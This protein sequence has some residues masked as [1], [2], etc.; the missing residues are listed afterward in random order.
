MA[1]SKLPYVAK[2]Q[3]GRIFARNAL[4]LTVTPKL[5]DRRY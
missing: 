1:G 5:V 4:L 3:P 2:R